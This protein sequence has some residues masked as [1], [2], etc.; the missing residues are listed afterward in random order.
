MKTRKQRAAGLLGRCLLV[1][2]L[3][4]GVG[5]CES[6][7][8]EELAFFSLLEGLASANPNLTPQERAGATIVRGETNIERQRRYN[9]EAAREGQTEVNVYGGNLP[10]D[11]FVVTNLGTGESKIIP[12]NQWWQYAQAHK[13]DYPNGNIITVYKDYEQ[14]ITLRPKGSGKGKRKMITSISSK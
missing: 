8:D 1:G 3:A 4:L 14:T 13:E 11:Y 6:A 5:S 10:P 7:S 2:G 9:I 12:G